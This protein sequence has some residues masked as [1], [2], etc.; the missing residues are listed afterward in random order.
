V[1]PEQAY[2]E[3][4]RRSRDENLLSSTLDL[5]EWDEEVMMPRGGSDHRAEQTALLAGLVH[6]QATDPRYNELL[7]L[8]EASPLV[9]DPESAAAVNVREMRREFDRECKLPRRLVEEQ[10]RVTT[11]ATQHWATAKERSEYKPFAKWIDKLFALA[12]EE[13]DA[14]GYAEARYDALLEDYEPGL[15]ARDLSSLF[16]KL[17][18]ALAP[19]V[20][21][22]RGRSAPA[23]A[24]VVA[25][26]FAIDR[27]RVFFE[28]VATAIGFDFERGRVDVGRHPFCTSIGPGDVRIAI[29]YHPR[30]MAQG[31]FALL[32]EVGHALYDQGLDAEHYGTPIGE[33]VS[34]GVHESQSRLWEN[35]VG[36][37]RGFWTHFFPQLQGSFHDELR[38]VSADT[39]RRVINHPVPGPIRIYADEVHYDLHIVIRVE[40][41]Q[42]L[43]SGDLAAADLPGAW[44]E[45]YRKYLGVTPKDDREGCLQDTHWADGLI[46][47]FPTYTLGNMYAAQLFAAADREIGP[48]D[49][50]FAAG[51]FLTLRNWLG[52]RVHRH[53]SRYSAAATIE[54]A[55]GVPAD[56]SAMVASLRR[57]YGS[58]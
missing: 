15:T 18:P 23:P 40:L 3:L 16:G 42:A 30:N 13:A 34:L 37:S 5:L 2:A 29:K 47:Y 20:E 4:V 14:V 44:N 24:H 50:A 54:R 58:A 32:H 57:R 7:S 28:N 19:L 21:E 45:A 10:A 49:E 33:A 36:R 38:D 27:Q 41:E 51:D 25:R 9:A 43:L 48:L 31:L 46:G 55:T 1:T 17:T 8:V 12:R 11:L 39:F 22:V 56:P 6:D 26:D 52:E 53:G 35:H